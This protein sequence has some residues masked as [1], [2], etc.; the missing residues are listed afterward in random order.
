MTDLFHATEKS[1][2]SIYQQIRLSTIYRK[3]VVLWEI[4]A[5]QIYCVEGE[6][7]MKKDQKLIFQDKDRAKK[8]FFFHNLLLSWEI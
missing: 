5:G 3:R 6:I 7:K 8:A 2:K 1:L 4:S